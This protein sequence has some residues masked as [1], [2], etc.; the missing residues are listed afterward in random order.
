MDYSKERFATSHRLAI[1]DR[2]HCSNRTESNTHKDKLKASQNG[3]TMSELTP[4]QQR[5]A[6]L[7]R[8]KGESV[9]FDMPR[10][11][12]DSWY[13]TETLKENAHQGNMNVQE[14]LPL[15]TDCHLLGH[16]V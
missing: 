12:V 1:P 15:L 6:Q 4:A 5:Q 16:V 10:R 11:V 13:H 7:A 2:I 8:L 9:F 14:P 3:G